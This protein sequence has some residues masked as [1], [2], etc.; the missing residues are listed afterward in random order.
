[1]A[2][3]ELLLHGEGCIDFSSI[4]LIGGESFLNLFQG[5]AAFLSDLVRAYLLV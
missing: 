1:M 3:L 4:S 2:G 5:Q